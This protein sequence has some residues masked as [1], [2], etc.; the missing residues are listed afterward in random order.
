MEYA[1][2]QIDDII[3][4]LFNGTASPDDIA[5]LSQLPTDSISSSNSANGTLTA[6]AT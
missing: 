4:R 1:D 3:L 6:V 5:T 2:I